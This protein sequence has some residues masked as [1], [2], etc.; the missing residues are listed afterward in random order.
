MSRYP[1]DVAILDGLYTGGKLNAGQRE[2]LLAGADPTKFGLS[3]YDLF[4]LCPSLFG[5]TQLT[6]L[7]DA[8]I[9]MALA[10]ADPALVAATVGGGQVLSNKQISGVT[11]TLSSIPNS[12]LVYSALLLTPGAGLVGGGLTALG[13]TANFAAYTNVQAFTTAGS[14]TWTKPLNGNWARVLVKAGDGGSGSG[15]RQ[16]ASGGGGGGG[17]GGFSI[18]EGPLTDLGSSVAYIVGG[19]GT[20]GAA[21]TVNSTNGNPGVAGGD[22]SFGSLAYA[23]GG[24]GGGGGLGGSGTGGSGGAGGNGM[25]VGG[26][27]GAGGSPAGPGSPGAS[28]AMAGAGGGGGGGGSNTPLQTAGGAGGSVFGINTQGGGAGPTFTVGGAGTSNAA[29]HRPG[30]GGGGGGGSGDGATPA[31]AGGVGGGAAGGGGGSANGANSGAGAAGSVGAIYV[32]VW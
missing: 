23:Y 8:R 26:A 27:G 14:G 28:A 16:T 19:G 4:A 2:A 17:G 9:A 11:N 5:L 13:G 15:A 1:L 32:F 24:G 22:S 30:S 18:W 7:V 6:Q 12:A 20:G 31:G 10:V 21:V 25:F 29:I 3:P